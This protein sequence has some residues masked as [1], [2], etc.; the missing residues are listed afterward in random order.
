M[1]AGGCFRVKDSHPRSKSRRRKATK[2][3]TVKRESLSSVKKMAPQSQSCR[4]SLWTWYMDSVAHVMDVSADSTHD[5]RFFGM[6][7]VLSQK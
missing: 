3:V 1:R 4:Y 2:K 5:S 7:G 6:L